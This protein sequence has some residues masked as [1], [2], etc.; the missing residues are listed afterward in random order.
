MILWSP[1]R[2]AARLRNNRAGTGTRWSLE[3]LRPDVL[4]GMQYRAD[5]NIR[6]FLR[7]EDVMRL[8]AEAS[9]PLRQFVNPLAYTRE[10]GEKAKRALQARVIGLA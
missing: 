1:E 7:V 2:P 9:I 4:G 5:E 6:R 8:K 3:K 10:V